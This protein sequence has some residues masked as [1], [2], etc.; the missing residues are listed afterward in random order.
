LGQRL[1]GDNPENQIASAFSL[2]QRELDLCDRGGHGHGVAD[3]NFAHVTGLY[4]VLGALRARY[5]ELLIENVSGG[6]NRLD[7][8]M[9]RYSDVGWMDDRS[10]PSVH[11]RHILGGLSALFP[12][13]YLLSFVMEH[14]AEP[15]REASDIPLYFRSRSPGI[16]GL[17]FRTG[18][19]SDDDRAKMASEIEIYKMIRDALGTGAAALLTP[20]AAAEGGPSWDVLQVSSLG[21]RTIVLSAIQWDAGEDEVTIRP[22]G[23]RPE[24][25]YSVRSVDVGALGSA[26][27]AELMADGVRVSQSPN[28]AAHIIVIQRQ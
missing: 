13:A 16:L 6:G 3:G 20:Q 11:V 9:L 10:A 19:V 5:P 25:S 15:L 26:T 21:G 28:S 27:G 8:G 24:S 2:Q 14:E 7:L 17:C 18:Q 22:Q 12:P 23:L 4:D 1:Q